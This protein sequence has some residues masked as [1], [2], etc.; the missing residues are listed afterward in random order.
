MAPVTT[1][2]PKMVNRA[3]KSDIADG[4][5]DAFP[6]FAAYS[7]ETEDLVIDSEYGI[8]ID[9]E[10]NTVVASKTGQAELSRFYDQDYDADRCIRTLG[11]FKRH[12][13]LS[14]RNI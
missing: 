3:E 1:A 14:S 11:R 10:S 13:Y 12:I 8:L 7:D 5:A 2:P 4:N 6:T 9:L